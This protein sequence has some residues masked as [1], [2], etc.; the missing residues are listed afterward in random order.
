MAGEVLVREAE[1]A[2][3]PAIT[4][5]LKRNLI[6]HRHLD[7][8]KPIEWVGHSPFLM[9]E[10]DHRLQALLVCPPDPKNVYWIRILACLLTIPIEESYDALFPIAVEKIRRSNKANVITS[11]AY[12]DWMQTLLSQKGWEICQQVVQLRW[13]RRKANLY[14]EKCPEGYIIRPMHLPDLPSV[15]LIDRACF[16]F[17]WQHSEDALRRAFEQP[18]YCTVAEKDG[19]LVGYQITTRQRNRAHIARLAVLPDFQRLRIGYCLVS[20]VINQFRKSWAR[21]ISVN[22]QMDNFKSLSLYNKV[23]FEQTDESF[24]IY[25]YKQ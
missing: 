17:L 19:I 23:G 5:F 10:N 8:C 13:N 25:I 24:P 6:L 12:Q 3:I 15:A 20:D 4:E 7:W 18:T 11:I 2:D 21:E 22:T 1:S 9:L 16:D 14:A